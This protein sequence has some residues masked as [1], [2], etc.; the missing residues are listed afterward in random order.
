MRARPRSADH[1]AR[2]RNLRTPEGTRSASGVSWARHCSRPFPACKR[3]RR[4]A[5]RCSAVSW[6]TAPPSTACS[7]RSRH[8]GSS[9]SKC[10]APGNDKEVRDAAQQRNVASGRS[11]RTTFTRPGCLPDVGEAQ[12]PPLGQGHPPREWQD[13]ADRGGAVECAGRLQPP[14]RLRGNPVMEMDGRP[15]TQSAVAQRLVLTARL[16]P[17][18]RE[19]ALE[20][21]GSIP[22]QLGTSGF[23]RLG[24]Y[25]SEREVV[26]LIEAREAELLVREILDDPVRATEI[27][28]WLP[29][30]DG[31]LHRAAEVYHWSAGE[32]SEPPESHEPCDDASS[33][34]A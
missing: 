31:P 11:R 6:P 12:W 15:R 4:G 27:S 24:V 32:F 26:F 19:R 17:G 22:A 25:L 5:K 30:F 3:G 16:R 14:V 29:L 9:C 34:R 33:H 7:P 13:G 8:S 18:S 10:T 21:V 1:R 20:L 23:E 28:P 2:C